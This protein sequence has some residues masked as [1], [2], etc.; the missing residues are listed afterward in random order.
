MSKRALCMGINNYPGTGM[1]LQ[2]CVNDATDW[3]AELTA[4]GFQVAGIAFRRQN[5]ADDLFALL[6]MFR[7]VV[8]DQAK[9]ANNSGRAAIV[10]PGRPRATGSSA[11]A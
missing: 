11:T 7:L 10:T 4:R 9:G 1:D 6:R 8:D 5:F 3:A 2:G